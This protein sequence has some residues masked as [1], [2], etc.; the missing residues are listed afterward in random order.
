M[1]NLIKGLFGALIGS[2]DPSAKADIIMCIAT[3]AEI[4]AGDLVGVERL[5]ENLLSEPPAEVRSYFQSLY[6][7][8]TDYDDDRRELYDI[9]EC[10][11]WFQRIDRRYPFLIYFVPCVQYTLFV[12]SQCGMN[13]SRL[14]LPQVL[15]FLSNRNVALMELARRIEEPNDVMLAKLIRSIEDHTKSKPHE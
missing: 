7:L 13:G 2:T 14:T 9:P 11:N 5:V 12:G 15:A 3:R 10:R 4:V 8:V 6:F 1:I